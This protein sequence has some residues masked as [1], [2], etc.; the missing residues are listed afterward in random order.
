[1]APVECELAKVVMSENQDRQVIILQEK[2]NG[3]QLPIIIGLFE[4]FAIHRFLNEEPPPRPLTHELVGNI[5][6]A[7]DASVEKVVVNDLKDMTF[8]A[9]LF[10]NQ[11]GT[12]YEVDSRPSDGIALAVQASAP[13]FVEEAV[14]EEAAEEP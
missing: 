10:I 8:Y 11:D 12:T 4:V 14:L 2:E 5:F 1:M 9:R 6:E 13:I 7:M 3:R